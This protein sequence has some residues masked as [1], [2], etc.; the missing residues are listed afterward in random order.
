M[1]MAAAISN[2]PGPLT[3]SGIPMRKVLVCWQAVSG[4]MAACC[5][6]LA[7]RDDLEVHALFHTPVA[8]DN[9]D[10]STG[11]LC[12]LSHRLLDEKER[13]DAALI[14]KLALEYKPDA[15]ILSG[16]SVSS[17]TQLA[18]E[19]ALAHS[20][21]IMMID[22]QRRYNLRQALARLK[23]GRLLDRLDYL[24]VPGERSWQLARYLKLPMH[25]IQRG[26]L[27]FDFASFSS[28]LEERRKNSSGWPRNFLYVGKYET[29]KGIDCLLEAHR[30]YKSRNEQ[31]WS[32]RCCGMGP[33]AGKIRA[34]EGVA[35]LGFQQPHELKKAFLAA[36]AFILPSLFEPWGIALVE[37]CAAGLPVLC[38]DECGASVEVVR[39]YFNGLSLETGN[40]IALA[41]GME[42][43]QKNYPNLPEIGRRSRQ[44]AEPFSADMWAE[45]VSS[46]ILK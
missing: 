17:Y 32:L 21:F 33:L 30:I 23:I 18:F 24:F 46:V 6:A 35:D 40:V 36:G 25:K 4:Y 31:A 7:A 11:I 28:L 12:G 13:H 5:R 20:K 44:M 1:T 39:S 42:W 43:I 2:L 19:K 8:A 27:G 34:A 45:R 41:E 10:F 9:A 22:T 15:V 29:R 37:A 3:G 16:W 14:R 26:A 38:S